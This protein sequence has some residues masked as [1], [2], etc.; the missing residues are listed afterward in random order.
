MLLEAKHMVSLVK[1]W[2][3]QTWDAGPW[4]CTAQEIVSSD[5]A[6]V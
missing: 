3:A 5:A 2:A 1:A 6:H 4:K